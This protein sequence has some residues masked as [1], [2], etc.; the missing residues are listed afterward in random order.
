[1]QPTVSIELITPDIAEAMLQHNTHNRPIS[2]MHLDALITEMKEGRFAFN[3]AS[4]V[5]AAD[6]TLLDGQHRL[7]A[8]VA[9][10]VAIRA[11]VV[12]GVETA[13]QAT[14]DVGRK[15]TLADQLK[16]RGHVN[17]HLVASGLRSFEQI[18]RWISGDFN[19]FEYTITMGLADLEAHPKVFD[20]ATRAN[21]PGTARPAHLTSSC[22]VGLWLTLESVAE[23][24]EV[25]WFF[26]TYHRYNTGAELPMTTR[27]PIWQLRESVAKKRQSLPPGTGLQP[28]WISAMCI[29]AWNLYR[30]DAEVGTLKFTQ[31][32]RGSEKYPVPR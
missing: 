32:G 16:L 19:P 7:R 22:V 30:D 4:I 12:R 17:H 13:A 27:S 31:V 18:R 29:K 28:K 3:G 20:I 11:V 14:Q 9:S 15:R 21:G 6:L 24:D 26:E 25:A 5:Q 1:M 23:P 2:Q 10:G 8:V